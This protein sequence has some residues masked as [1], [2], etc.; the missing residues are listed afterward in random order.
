[1]GAEKYL[2]KKL[3]FILLFAFFG[4]IGG[5]ISAFAQEDVEDEE[6]YEEVQDSIKDGFVMGTMVLPNPP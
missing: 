3:Q 4:F 6:D 2:I 5:D 1:M